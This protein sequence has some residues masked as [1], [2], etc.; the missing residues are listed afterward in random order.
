[1]HI[2]TLDS[3]A[4]LIHVV[5][6]RCE[7]IH[8]N[9]WWR[10]RRHKQELRKS[11]KHV[12]SRVVKI[13]P[14]GL[15]VTP[16]VTCHSESLCPEHSKTSSLRSTPR[17]K[18]TRIP[19]P[20]C[21]YL[22]QRVDGLSVRVILQN[23]VPSFCLATTWSTQLRSARISA[24]VDANDIGDRDEHRSHRKTFWIN[25]WSAS[26]KVWSPVV[27]EISPEGL[28]IRIWL[29]VVHSTPPSIAN[30]L[31]PTAQRLPLTGFSV[32]FFLLFS[33]FSR[34][35]FPNRTLLEPTSISSLTNF[36][37][38]V[39]FHFVFHR[40]V[41][42]FLT[43]VCLARRWHAPT[44]SK[45]NGQT[46]QKF[47]HTLAH[48]NKNTNAP[49]TRDFLITR[50]CSAS[51]I[52]QTSTSIP[53]ASWHAT[54]VKQFRT[55]FTFCFCFLKKVFQPQLKNYFCLCFSHL[56]S[57]TKSKVVFLHT[58]WNWCDHFDWFLK[59]MKENFWS[60]EICWS[61]EASIFFELSI[62]RFPF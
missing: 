26:C 32:S 61:F 4:W 52:D 41:I 6:A 48:T 2:L 46:H 1:M 36:E 39:C 58:L 56:F 21:Q 37:I 45:T 43:C 3:T 44:S 15:G 7:S 23:F 60:W 13:S 55:A 17:T 19:P 25:L 20:Q 50:C 59:F 40:C 38:R 11:C 14:S 16:A 10:D 8:L 34:M 53:S 5:F 62:L 33:S 31:T 51:M 29:V 57:N 49:H 42:T 9:T 22:Q 54:K 30:C 28:E 18:D 24:V 27:S 35:S 47:P 12:H